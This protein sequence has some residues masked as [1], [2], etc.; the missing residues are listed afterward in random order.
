MSR[1]VFFFFYCTAS[2]LSGVPNRYKHLGASQVSLMFAPR[3]S[4]TCRDIPALSHIAIYP[5]LACELTDF[6]T[7]SLVAACHEISMARGEDD[8]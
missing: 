2:G 8:F 1:P 3:V 4:V 5:R 6:L 7:F